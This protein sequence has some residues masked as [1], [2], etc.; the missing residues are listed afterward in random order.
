M[1]ISGP[2]LMFGLIIS[3]R[4]TFI[5][6]LFF[7]VG[8]MFF[9]VGKGRVKRQFWLFLLSIIGLVVFVLISDPLGIIGRLFGALIMPTEEGSAYI[10]LMEYPNILMNIYH[11]PIFG[12]PIGTP[13]FQYY[14]MPIFANYTQFGCHNSYLY[15]PLRTGIIGT[16]AFFWFLGRTW[17]AILINL[18]TEK[19]EED[20][21][22]NQLLLHSM[23]IYNFSCFFGLMY[24][25][26]MN[27]MTGY[28]LV[29]VQLQMTHQSGLISYRKVRIWK[30]FKS[31][32]LIF[33][34]PV[35]PINLSI[36]RSAR[37]S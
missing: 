8:L 36:P 11:H 6:G 35:M 27:I 33:R 1:F 25:D 28:L 21:L 37:S 5:I 9:S 22:M 31:K 15:W 16:V 24:A 13:W 34:K 2:V 23:I 30:T 17:K 3:F 18:R 26:A 32:K 20:F 4:R 29:M 12:I 7:S 14:R 19:T 10:R